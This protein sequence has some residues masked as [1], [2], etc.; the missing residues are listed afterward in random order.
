MTE[1]EMFGCISLVFAI[2]LFVVAIVLAAVY[3]KDDPEDGIED[4]EW[5][6]REYCNGIKSCE[7]CSRYCQDKQKCKYKLTIP[8]KWTE[9][10]D[11]DVR[12]K[13]RNTARI[14]RM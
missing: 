12:R 3:E 13:E 5:I 11:N 4:A 1:Y 6:I 8:G 9:D 7:A 2:A 10:E 14:Q